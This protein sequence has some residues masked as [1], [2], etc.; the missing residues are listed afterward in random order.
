LGLVSGL[1]FGLL[2]GG[3]DEKSNEHTREVKRVQW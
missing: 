1:V 2:I 3:E